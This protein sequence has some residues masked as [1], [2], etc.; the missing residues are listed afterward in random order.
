MQIGSGVLARAIVFA[1]AVGL[2]WIGMGFLAYGLYLLLIPE[3]G[4][5]GA[6]FAA[7]L[8][9][10]AIGAGAIAVMF[11]RA[12]QPQL[13]PRVAVETPVV[14]GGT[15]I[16]ALSELAQDHPLMAV[17]CAAILGATNGGDTVKRR[18]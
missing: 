15:M 17:A 3:V 1:A 18:R 13:E 16:K 8:I 2:T 9:C 4:L 5:Y 7:A 14:E 11:M 12:P 6:A 10:V